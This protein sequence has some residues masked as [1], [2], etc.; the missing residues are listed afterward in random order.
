MKTTVITDR[1]HETT[2]HLAGWRKNVEDCPRRI[3]V[4]DQE[5]WLKSF[6]TMIHPE[7]G[8][9]VTKILNVMDWDRRPDP[10][11]R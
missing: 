1:L 8:D 6:V 11:A 9:P 10:D 3:F 4:K 5:A 2:L 7:L